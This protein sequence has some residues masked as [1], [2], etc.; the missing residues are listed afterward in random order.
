MIWQ[1]KTSIIVMLTRF[2]EK[3]EKKA[4]EYFP[5][6][7][8]K[9]ITIGM[10]Q[11]QNNLIRLCSGIHISTL[12][13][14][15]ANETRTIYHLQYT[16]WP[17]N[18]IPEDSESI[19]DLVNL[20]DLYKQSLQETL[21]GPMIVHCS[22]GVGR[23]GTFIAIHHSIQLLKS[24]IKPRISSIVNNIREQRHGCIQNGFQYFFIFKVVNDFIFKLH[25]KENLIFSLEF[26][27][28]ERE[29]HFQV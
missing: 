15:K 2:E 12:Q 7:Q 14:V 9:K 13:L 8:G 11:I 25:Q 22:A 18:E 26:F 24:S 5:T 29:K 16:T 27:S 17:D 4:D 3:G 10:F 19:L 6:T 21:N 20:C 23:S 28:T 1:Q